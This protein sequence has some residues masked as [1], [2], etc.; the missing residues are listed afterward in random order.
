V[1]FHLLVTF[2][3]DI[4]KRLES[5]GKQEDDSPFLLFRV[6]TRLLV[7]QVGTDEAAGRSLRAIK[8]DFRT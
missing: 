5:L 7:F 3:C 1:V 2:I 4:K 6:K 8:R